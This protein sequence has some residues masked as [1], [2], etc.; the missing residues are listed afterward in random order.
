MKKQA[1]AARL[2]DLLRIAAQST[3]EPLG[4][5]E[6]GMS[7]ESVTLSEPVAYAFLGFASELTRQRRWSE[8]VSEEYVREHLVPILRTAREEGAEAAEQLFDELITEVESYSIERTVYVPITGMSLSVEA[9]QIGQVA[10]T[11]VDEKVIHRLGQILEPNNAPT[12]CDRR[13]REFVAARQDDFAKKLRGKICAE[14]RTIAEPTRAKERA[15]EETRWALELVTY[16]NAALHPFDHQADAVVGLD[17]ELPIVGPWIA[18]ASSGAFHHY[19]R[20]APT[21]WPIPLTPAILEQFESVGFWKLSD[22]L[23]TPTDQRTKLDQALL[24]AVHWFAASQRQVELEGRLLNL[25][26]GT[27]RTRGP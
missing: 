16:A 26:R 7:W 2:K 24:H 8:H 9:L 19:L 18:V 27:I 5:F 1:Q 25:S 15:E 11:E 3:S 17:G 23:A 4:T 21:S 22:L 6:R 20:R 10:I 13:D 12:D 14:F